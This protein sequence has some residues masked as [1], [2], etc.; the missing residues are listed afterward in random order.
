MHIEILYIAIPLIVTMLTIGLFL[1]KRFKQVRAD[2]RKR[3]ALEQ[4]RQDVQNKA[5]QWVKQVL[6]ADSDEEV[7]DTEGFHVYSQ[8]K[9]WLESIPRYDHAQARYRAASRRSR[10][11]ERCEELVLSLESD[12][13]FGRYLALVEI[14]SSPEYQS[15]TGITDMQAKLSLRELFT[16][17]I[18]QVR[19]GDL[20]A[21]NQLQKI[22][23]DDRR[24]PE[25]VNYPEDW[26]DLVVMHLENPYMADFIHA[27]KE[28]AGGELRLLAAEALRTSSLKDAKIVLAACN[29]WERRH[30][31]EVGDVLLAELAKFVEKE[32]SE[33]AL[34]QE[35][36]EAV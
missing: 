15:G 9:P 22:F 24:R 14:H 7:L 16:A 32:N 5:K 11:K 30:S 4:E 25:F 29:Q 26:D 27:R 6:G 20:D 8:Q 17:L 23:N 13:V 21:F 10:N 35:L 12:S 1:K 33:L 19:K 2:T 3:Q 36:K 31:K 18:N 34:S 28:F